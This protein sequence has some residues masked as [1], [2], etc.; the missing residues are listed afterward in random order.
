LE[1]R[2]GSISFG[3]TVALTE[4]TVGHSQGVFAMFDVESTKQLLC[5]KNAR[6]SP[7]GVSAYFVKVNEEWGIKVFKYQVDRDI[8]YERQ[9]KAAEFGLGPNV[10]PKMDFDGMYCMWTEVA[11]LICTDWNTD[12]YYKLSKDT[13]EIR[14]ELSQQLYDKIGFRFVDNHILNI[15][16][17]R[18]EYVCIDFAE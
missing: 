13:D 10:G 7:N 11:E 18:G 15:G 12:E 1:S 3:V 17:L 8:S 4:S 5:G 2:E 9:Q 16:I 14:A 6:N